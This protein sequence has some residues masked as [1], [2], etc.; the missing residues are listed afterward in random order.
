MAQPQVRRNTWEGLP[1]GRS[2]VDTT[3]TELLHIYIYD[4]CKKHNFNQAARFFAAEANVSA[5]QRP[6]IDIATGFLADW[7]G[8]FLDVYHAQNKDITAT[9]G[10]GVH[11]E[12]H[13][14]VRNRK[15]EVLQ[16]QRTF[17]M[18]QAI[19]QQQLRRASEMQRLGQSPQLHHNQVQQTHPAQPPH[20]P[21]QQQQQQLHQQQQQQQLAQSRDHRSSPVSSIASLPNNGGIPPP[22]NNS[23]GGPTNGNPMV[24]TPQA[25]PASLPQ[26]QQQQQQQAP[27]S[28]LG[29]SS[30]SFSPQQVQRPGIPGNGG[31]ENMAGHPEMMNPAMMNTQGIPMNPQGQMMMN[32]Q[33]LVVNPQNA[34][35]INI[36]NALGL[37]GRDPQTLTPDERANVQLHFRRQTMQMNQHGMMRNSNMMVVNNPTQARLQMQQQMIANQQMLQQQQQQRQQQAQLHHG[38]PQT[39]QMQHQLQHG[40]PQPPQQQHMQHSQSQHSQQHQP[41]T[42]QQQAQSLPQGQQRQHGQPPIQSQQ[43]NQGPQNH[44]QSMEHQQL[45]QQQQHD[46]PQPTHSVMNNQAGNGQRIPGAMTPD[47]APITGQGQMV[48]NVQNSEQFGGGEGMN[49]MMAEQMMKNGQLSGLT[50]QQQQ[51]QQQFLME[52]Y[53]QQ[54]RTLFSQRRMMQQ[55]GG[56]VP[57]NP[58]MMSPIPPAPMNAGSPQD[59]DKNNA[60]LAQYQRQ[61]LQYTMQQRQQYNHH[62][63]QQQQQ[64]QQQQPNFSQDPH[65]N[66]SQSPQMN[67]NLT[68]PSAPHQQLPTQKRQLQQ[69]QQQQHNQKR[70]RANNDSDGTGGSQNAN[71]SPSPRL[72]NTTPIPPN[73]HNL[74]GS[75]HGSPILSQ[76]NYNQDP[77]NG[78]NSQSP[79]MDR[80]L[81]KPPTPQQKQTRTPQQAPRQLPSSVSSQQEQSMSRMGW[82]PSPL[83]D[84]GNMQSSGMMDGTKSPSTQPSAIGVDTSSGAFDNGSSNNSNMMSFDLERFMMSD[85]G[86]FGEIF[87]TEQNLL[88]GSENNELF[89]GG[90]LSNMGGGGFGGEASSSLGGIDNATSVQVYGQLTGHNNKVNTVAFSSDAQ[91]LASAG[92][93]KKVMVWSVQEKQLRWT[94][95]GHT[96]Q[97]TCA[98]WS[99]DQRNLLVTSSYDKSLRV[100]D[101]GQAMKEGGDGVKQIAKFSC[102]AQIT[103]VDFAPNRPDTICSLD[104]EGELNVW[105]ISSS[106]NEKTIK[107]A[108][109]K[110][111][112][113]ANPLRFHPRLGKILACAAGNQIFIINIDAA[114][115]NTSTGDSSAVRTINVEHSKNICSLDWSMDGSYLVT[116]SENEVMVYETGHWK[117]INKHTA[118]D[119]ISACAFMPS[120]TIDNSGEAT[121]GQGGGATGARKLCVV[122]GCYQFIYVWQCNVP[123]SQP[124]RMGKQYGMVAGLTCAHTNGQYIVASASH[125]KED[126]L[127]LWTL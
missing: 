97:I 32:Q 59:A 69:Q 22:N 15:E 107:M 60:S 91:W 14:L 12:Y 51:Q 94:L 124:Q 9:K 73:T 83:G 100:W 5:D 18:Q 104:A 13:E 23:T 120:T 90:F 126:N 115:N 62:H 19:Q 67:R 8:V 48:N 78:S 39:P 123:G 68:K 26:Q 63:Q 44:H 72:M 3:E 65:A 122:Y 81:T 36:M 38:Q 108:A 103:A 64:Q 74:P 87:T 28:R 106:K 34:I 41:P 80:G 30:P 45:Q 21:S 96:Q 111:L 116:S 95:E 99:P 53:H 55:Q 57:P 6:P 113:A 25:L 4:Y 61:Q 76:P 71:Q 86:D 121:Q 35:I 85:G 1:G 118:T 16:Q 88:M 49:M 117:L 127:M 11:D 109:S 33:R 37:G 20:V 27:T 98:R 24:N 101:L 125:H 92:H 2:V 75:S 77:T 31:N 40:Q 43:G 79:Q 29:T 93:D 102:K 56:Q 119:K 82:N 47:N 66:S 54:Q 46:I 110:S 50:Q 84:G 52:H 17:N 105:N 70:Q 58:S 89:G 10:A 112:F 114:K 42:P 7:W